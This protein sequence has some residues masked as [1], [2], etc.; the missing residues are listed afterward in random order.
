MI[1]NAFGDEC[2]IQPDGIILGNKKHSSIFDILIS[3]YA[4]HA[5]PDQCITDPLKAYKEFPGSMPYVGAFA[6]HTE[7]LLVS[8]VSEI[9]NKIQKITKNLNGN[10][11]SDEIGGDFSFIVYP[12]PKIALCYI[13]YDADE[14]FP[15]SVTCLYSNNANQFLPV[16]GLADVG[17]YCSKKILELIE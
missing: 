4:L 16:D 14:D 12:L 2:I 15:A 7:Q 17:E 10:E 1:F 5:C 11:A 6:T 8:Y 3:L 13:F 9:K